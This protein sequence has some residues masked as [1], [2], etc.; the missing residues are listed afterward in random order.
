M[1]LLIDKTLSV[2]IKGQNHKQLEMGA[3]TLEWIQGQ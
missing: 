1:I 3:W 2:L